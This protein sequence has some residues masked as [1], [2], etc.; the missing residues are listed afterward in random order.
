MPGNSKYL[1]FCDKIITR[2]ITLEMGK[3]YDRVYAK[4]SSICPN[5]SRVIP[6][7]LHDLLVVPFDGRPIPILS[8]TPELLPLLAEPGR[9]GLSLI[10]EPIPDLILAGVTCP[11][12]QEDDVNW[13]SVDDDSAYCG[14]RAVMSGF[15]RNDPVTW[16]TEFKSDHEARQALPGQIAAWVKQIAN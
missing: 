3:D 9:C 2:S 11:K 13:L 4:R 6:S 1:K 15:G 10:G 5:G 7:D 12:S 14:N 16:K 8:D